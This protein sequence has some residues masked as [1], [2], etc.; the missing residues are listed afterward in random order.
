MKTEYDFSKMKAR[1]NPYAAKVKKIQG[2]SMHVLEIIEIGDDLGFILPEDLRKKL[3]AHA[4][5]T[6]RIVE[7][8]TGFTILANDSA[9]EKKPKNRLRI[10]ARTCQ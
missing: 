10:N 5:D 6:L 1:K 2:A 4:D 7:T 8:T 9:S 3:N